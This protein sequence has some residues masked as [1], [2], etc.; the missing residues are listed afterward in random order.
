MT[1]VCLVA[2]SLNGQ[3]FIGKLLKYKKTE[4]LNSNFGLLAIVV[5]PGFRL[6]LL[7]GSLLEEKLLK[8]NN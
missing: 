3:H 8:Q 6:C 5:A 7:K 2:H 4:Y 1:H